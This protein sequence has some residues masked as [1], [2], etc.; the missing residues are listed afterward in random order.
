MLTTMAAPSL[1][2]GFEQQALFTSGQ[3]GYHT[4]RIPSIITTPKGTT[5]AFCEGRKDAGGDSGN[6][7]LVLKRSTDSGK[8]WSPL[9]IV[10]DDADN[11]C[12][13]PCPVVDES[14][15]RIH[16]L[17]TWN[18]GDDHGRDL[19]AGQA[20]DTR[21]VFKTY[22][23]DEG[24]TWADPVEITAS[25]KDPS[26][27]WYATGPGVGIQLKTGPHKGRLVV[28]CDHTAPG[29]YYGSHTIYSDD[30]GETW[31]MSEPIQP[32]CN[33][34]QVVQL[35]DGRLMMNMRSQVS[36]SIGPK[37]RTGYRLISFSSDGGHSWT[38]PTSETELVDPVCQAS[39]IRLGDDPTK[40]LLFSNPNSP[41]DP[42]RGKRINMTVRLSDD[43][44]RTWPHAKVIHEGPSAYSCM[45]TLPDGS[46]GLFYEGGPESTYQN[47]Y[48]ARFSAGWVRGE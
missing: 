31:Q 11:T 5:L 6:I 38:P 9:Q 26:W 47:I 30:H 42:K 28:P 3:E 15:G 17:L 1:A 33:E 36:S 48:L 7:D 41:L 21:R 29:Y 14:T 16:L 46:V 10:W 43:D 24:L 34:C 32:G 4:F 19:H 12:G 35:R 20:K 40:P 22:S 13:N 45:T 27:W 23:D 39:L 37:T 44:G 8:T 18:R 2:A 25:T